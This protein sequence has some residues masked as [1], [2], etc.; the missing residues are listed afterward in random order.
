MVCRIPLRDYMEDTISWHYDPKGHFSVRSA[1][2]IYLQEQAHKEGQ[3]GCSIPGPGFN[4]NKNWGMNIPNNTLPL[5]VNIKRCRVHKYIM[6]N[7]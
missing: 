7:L 2:K 5:K 6:S 4:W 3:P 1:Y